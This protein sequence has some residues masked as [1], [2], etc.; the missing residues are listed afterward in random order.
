MQSKYRQHLGKTPFGC[1]WL[2][3]PAWLVGCLDLGKAHTVMDGDEQ[4]E[5]RNFLMRWLLGLLAVDCLRDTVLDG[6]AFFLLCAWL[7]DGWMG[8]WMD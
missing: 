2:V 7:M 8:G 1:C 4:G 6:H 5:N 3:R